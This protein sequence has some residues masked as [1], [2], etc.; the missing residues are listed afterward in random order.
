M[1]TGRTPAARWW[2]IGGATPELRYPAVRSPSAEVDEEKSRLACWLY[3]FRWQDGRVDMDEWDRMI[4]LALNDP[5]SLVLRDFLI[6]GGGVGLGGLASQD[7]LRALM[8]GGG[9]CG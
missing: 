3:S 2:R 6:A 8:E 5:L 9:S 1:R 7:R 4:D